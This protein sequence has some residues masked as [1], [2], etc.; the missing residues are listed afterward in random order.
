MPPQSHAGTILAQGIG[1]LG[2]ALGELGKERQRSED[3]IRA[4]REKVQ[5]AG[6]LS[7][8]DAFGEDYHD[9]VDAT[10]SPAD[11]VEDFRAKALKF[12]EPLLKDVQGEGLRNS[13]QAH[14]QIYKSNANS[15]LL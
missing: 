9:T 5:V 1:Q 6:I 13:A 2:E 7:K 10:K 8:L 15:P 12:A 11:T 14:I 4:S 3:L